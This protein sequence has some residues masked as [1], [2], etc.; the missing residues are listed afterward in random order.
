ML[1][2]SLPM[3]VLLK[4]TVMMTTT[5]CFL[6]L[7]HLLGSPWN[8]I[9]LEAL[10]WSLCVAAWLSYVAW[11]WPSLGFLWPFL[12]I[13][14]PCKNSHGFQKVAQLFNL[15]RLFSNQRFQKIWVCKKVL[16]KEEILPHYQNSQ[17]FLTYANSNKMSGPLHVRINVCILY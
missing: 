5:L 9:S 3:A 7:E 1:N 6:I 4:L 13:L 10:E 15:M 17:F 12:Q 2:I 14:K 8:K 11:P 16:L